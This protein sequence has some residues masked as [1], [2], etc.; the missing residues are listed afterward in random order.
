M[1]ILDGLVLRD[2]DLGRR[3]STEVLGAGDLMRPWESDLPLE[4]LPLEA[5]WNVLEEARIALLDRR[6]TQAAARW[7]AMIDE[8]AGR[9]LRRTRILA[10]R[11]LINQLV[12]L[13]DRLLLALWA[14]GERWG[15]VTPDGVL[16]PLSLT[17]S[18]LARLVGARRPSVTSALGVLSREGLV[19]RTENGWL[20]RGDPS[21]VLEPLSERL[22]AGTP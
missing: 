18:T 21:S 2:L 16:V 1:L 19:E 15:R 5:R 12:R 13:E 9:A 6:F 7:P 4:S 11:L 3:S 20:L 14:M 17:H 22:T 10:L 8:V